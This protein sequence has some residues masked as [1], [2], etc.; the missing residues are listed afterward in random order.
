MKFQTFRSIF[1]FSQQN[2]HQTPLK[3]PGSVPDFR[4]ASGGGDLLDNSVEFSVHEIYT[5][6]EQKTRKG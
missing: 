2:R 1:K 5:R 3:L 6:L 4:E